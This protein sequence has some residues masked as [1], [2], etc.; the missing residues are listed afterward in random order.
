MALAIYWLG[1]S[2]E[3]TAH[4]W[5]TCFCFIASPVLNTKENK[6]MWWDHQVTYSLNSG[7]IKCVFPGQFKLVFPKH[8]PDK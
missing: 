5:G 2:E 4:G 3:V 7:A 6:G 8:L 1:S